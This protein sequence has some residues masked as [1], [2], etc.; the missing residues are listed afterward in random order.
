[1]NVI[2]NS[3]KPFKVSNCIYQIIVVRVEFKFNL[4]LMKFTKI[5]KNGNFV[6]H[7]VNL[8]VALLDRQILLH[9]DP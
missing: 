5:L 7:T 1:M 9:F 8:K 4:S 3:G 6:V 2:Y